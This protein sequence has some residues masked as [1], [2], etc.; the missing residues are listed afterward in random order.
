M[1]IGLQT[2]GSNGDIRPMIALADGLQK[3]GHDTTLIVSSV[4]NRS[5]AETCAELG[6]AYQQVPAH[7]DF[8]M[9]DFAQR[10][11]KMTTL[12]WLLALLEASF[13]PYE[14]ELYTASKQ[15]AEDNDLVIGHHFLY[16]LKLAAKKQHKPH[17]SITY[18]HAAI[19]T[20]SQPPFKFPDLGRFLNRWQW[21]LLD[22]TFDWGLKKRL[23]RLWL[24]EGMPAFKHV[25]STMINSDLLNL[26]AAEP[27]L[28][29]YHHEWSA[30]NQVTG[31]FNL[32]EYAEPWQPSPA[33]QAF[34]AAG[35]QPVYMTFGSLQQAM[36]EWSMQLFI[37]AARLANCRAIIVSSSAQYPV[38][39]QQ[40]Q[41]FFIGL[42][43]HAPVFQRC[44]AVVHH[45]GAGTSQT[46]TLNGCP[47]IVV[48]FMDEQLFW[49]QQLH[50]ADLAAK[51]LPA[52]QAKAELLAER[53]KTV[54]NSPT[55][56]ANAQ[57]IAQDF[58]PERGVTKAV[59]LIEK[60]MQ[61]Q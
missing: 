61:D 48:P 5:Y 27:F 13:F 10:T 6:I 47:S 57:R 29:P 21:R 40:E 32:P 3:A 24:Q 35:E 46:A 50:L 59:E 7:M 11:F 9:Q 22:Y 60:I 43:P 14:Q 41:L 53:I 23:S 36:P 54:L 51:P 16:P 4:D 33:L 52:Q 17:I 56:R 25:F 30:L 38:D 1:K 37:E 44:A 20:Q 18:C 55:M 28:C 31:F 19:P 2:W 45:G 39:T 42:H 15:L 12:Q 58:N 8:D 49:G 34:L 26:V